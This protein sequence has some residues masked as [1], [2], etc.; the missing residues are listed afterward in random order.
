[1]S[2]DQ[3]PDLFSCEFA[4]TKALTV[5]SYGA[6]Q[7]STWLLYQSALSAEFRS[8]FAPGRLLVLGSDTSDEHSATYRQVEFSRKFCEL[9]GIP[10]YWVNS[11]MGFHSEAWSSLIGQYR[12]NN[13]IGSLMFKRCCTDNLKIQP[14]Y[15]FL[16]FWLH[17][18]Y[19]VPYDRTHRSRTF[20]A[21]L[22]FTEKL[23]SCWDSQ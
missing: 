4:S 14:F 18:N 13:T 16:A 2:I 12:R 3:Q 17:K 1:M 22:P 8:R 15:R 11:S 19:G 23:M 5:L 21:L 20:H 6:G 7:E 9:H 10:F